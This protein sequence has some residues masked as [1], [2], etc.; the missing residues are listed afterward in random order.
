M[1]NKHLRIFV[2][3][4]LLLRDFAISAGPRTAERCKTIA[5]KNK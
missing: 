2:L 5:E 4:D 3:V 1:P